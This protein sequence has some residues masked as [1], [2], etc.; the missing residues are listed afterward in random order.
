[1]YSPNFYFCPL[2]FCSEG[3]QL[4]L[5]VSTTHSCFPLFFFLISKFPLLL[6]HLWYPLLFSPFYTQIPPLFFHVNSPNF[7]FHSSP[8]ISFPKFLVFQLPLIFSA[9]LSSCIGPWT[10]WWHGGHQLL[11]PPC[12]MSLLGVGWQHVDIITSERMQLSLS[13]FLYHLRTEETLRTSLWATR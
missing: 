5:T 13:G 3:P 10:P 9:L 2:F 7:F 4:F 11:P 12:H 6:F 1:M 8:P